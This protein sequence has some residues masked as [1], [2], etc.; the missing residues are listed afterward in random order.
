MLD[1]LSTFFLAGM[2]TVQ[3]TTANTMM[4]LAQ[5]LDIKQRLL[6][7]IMPVIREVK[8]NIVEDFTYD[9]VQEFDFFYLLILCCN[10]G[11][12]LLFLSL[13]TCALEKMLQS[14]IYF[15]KSKKMFVIC[16]QAF[17]NDVT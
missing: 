2:K 5:N 10:S 13:S 15:Q 8:E 11:L 9:K 1:E 14:T 12:S 3:L 7:E 6:S 16:M 17:Q 4:F